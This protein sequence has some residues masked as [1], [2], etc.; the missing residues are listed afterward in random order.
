MNHL[1]LLHINH[2]RF[3]LGMF[4]WVAG[5]LVFWVG[6]IDAS[7]QT[8]VTTP[9]EQGPLPYLEQQLIVGSP[10]A[11]G[12]DE[13]SGVAYNPGRNRL[14][15]VEDNNQLHELDVTGDL[16]IVGLRRTIDINTPQTDIEGIAWMYADTYAILSENGGAI[17]IVDLPDAVGLTA[18][19]ATHIVHT[20]NTGI[21]ENGSG[22]SGSGAEGV[23]FDRRS[24]TSA[25]EQA[26]AIFY[27]VEENPAEI[28]RIAWDGTT[29]GPLAVPGLTDL[30]DIYLSPTGIL[31]LLSHEDNVIMEVGFD[32]DFGA[33]EIF[34]QQTL[35]SDYEQAEG[36]TFNADMSVMVVVS[37][38]DPAINGT[39]TAIQ[40]GRYARPDTHL[41][42]T[43]AEEMTTDLGSGTN[44]FSGITLNEDRN[45]L[46]VVDDGRLDAAADFVL[47]EFDL[48][49]H[50]S[51]TLRRTMQ[52]APSADIEGVA[53]MYADTYAILS[54]QNGIYIVDLP[55]DPSL[56]SV[57]AAHVIHQ[58]S[59]LPAIAA[60]GS[61]AEGIAF[62]PGSATG[63]ADQT[64]ARFYVVQEQP[65]AV[66]ETTWT[67]TTLTPTLTLPQLNDASGI[68][69]AADGTL[70][71]TS[72]LSQT[73]LQI[74][75]GSSYTSAAIIA[76]QALPTFQDAS[77]VTFSYDLS[78]MY[79]VSEHNGGGSSFGRYTVTAVFDTGCNTPTP[80]DTPTN[81]PT[82]TDTPTPT[83]PTPLQTSHTSNTAAGQQ[84]LSMFVLVIAA[85]IGTVGIHRF[86]IRTKD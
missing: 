84:N 34:S 14:L 69:A 78:T 18:V 45:R 40:F 48:D 27:V 33:V 38:D 63:S 73:L 70:F 22:F 65:A 25:A 2:Q 83:M 26:D 7:P 71:V 47:H 61:A 44:E 10:F 58:I 15:I 55:D 86:Y 43:L 5:L 64:N 54:E 35:P 75:V 67:G 37:E 9:G 13:F 29:T 30:S 60:D 77:G 80:T 11:G 66:Y 82:P 36:L 32:A 59:T 24:A 19:D 20:I 72:D 12:A 51:P 1:T 85:I 76:T 39:G 16:A 42:Y 31:Y 56:T 17:Y 6:Q 53:W 50:G 57:T 49:C 74:D 41:P 52:F 4:A 62:V 81:T 8:A 3:L 46:L 28:T 21:A 23:A 79:V 68:Y